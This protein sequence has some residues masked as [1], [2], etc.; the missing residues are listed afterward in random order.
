MDNT[1]I[2]KKTFLVLLR[3]GGYLLTIELWP[4]VS[5]YNTYINTPVPFT[6]QGIV[7][8][9]QTFSFN[10]YQ[11][12]T[13]HLWQDDKTE[14]QTN[15]FWYGEEE[16]LYKSVTIGQTN[17]VEGFNWKV[18]Q[19]LLKF[20]LIKPSRQESL[21]HSLPEDSPDLTRKRRWMKDR[22]EEV[23]VVEEV[24]LDES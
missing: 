3:F 19:K 7:T 6:A 10:A 22:V 21:K 24:R 17:K 1:Q 5:G 23:E 14:S 15:I 4:L 12:N 11:L 20:L 9:G 13:L 16:E 8:D 18:L 2:S